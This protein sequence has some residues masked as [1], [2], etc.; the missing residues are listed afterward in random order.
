MSAK[1]CPSD[2]PAAATSSRITARLRPGAAARGLSTMI[3]SA[4]KAA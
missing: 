2:S 4:A 1:L 3:W